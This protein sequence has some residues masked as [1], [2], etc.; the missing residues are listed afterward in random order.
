MPVKRIFIAI[1]ISHEARAAVSDYIDKMI[2]DFPRVRVGWE[3]PEKLHFTIR[4]LGDVDEEKL[5]Q[6]CGVVE[7]TVHKFEPFAVR[8]VETGVFPHYKNPK[9]L[10]LGPKQG[11]E[12]MANINAE[13][14]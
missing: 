1:D 7:R 11:S 3:R 10:W 6:V 9:V 12:E 8:I 4:F 2:I 13:I 5:S 14:E